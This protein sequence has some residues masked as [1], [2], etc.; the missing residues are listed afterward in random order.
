MG[1]IFWFFGGRNN[2]LVLGSFLSISK[3][4][5]MILLSLNENKMPIIRVEKILITHLVV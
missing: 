3:Q 1:Y 2:D 5:D 4:I